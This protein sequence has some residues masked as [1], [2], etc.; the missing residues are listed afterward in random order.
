MTTSEHKGGIVILKRYTKNQV[1]N[2]HCYLI[3]YNDDYFKI[4]LNK[5]QREK[6]FEEINKKLTFVDNKDEYERQSLSRTKRNIKEIALCNDFQYFATITVNNSICDRYNLQVCEEKL[7]KLCKKIRRKRK[8]FKY[9]FICEKHKDGA[10]HFHGL[11]KNLDLYINDNLYYSN[12]I[13]D[14]IG[15]NSFSKIKDYNK[16]C[17][18]ITKYIT[19]D[20]VRNLHNQIYFCSKGLKKATKYEIPIIN[21]DWS[22]ENDFC[23]IKEFSSSELSKN[24]IFQILGLY[25]PKEFE[26]NH[27][28]LGEI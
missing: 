9:V 26:K 24:D 5:F 2:S 13:F 7:Q 23:K 6:G 14:E 12:L 16:C 25:N 28:F 15:F 19:K 3:Q 18:Y 4:V 22:F 1:Y 11:V 8:D 27:K 10:Y 20:C 17:N 21:I